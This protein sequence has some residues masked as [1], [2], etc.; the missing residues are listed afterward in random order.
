VT[1]P[2]SQRY[3]EVSGEGGTRQILELVVLPQSRKLV[4]VTDAA[5]ALRGGEMFLSDLEK[6]AANTRERLG[7]PGL[8]VW[9]ADGL[10]PGALLALIG[11]KLPH[12]KIRMATVRVLR[13]AGFEVEPTLREYHHT[14]W[15]PAGYT[16]DTLLAVADRFEP[17]IA[18]EDLTGMG[19]ITTG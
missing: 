13:E 14:I 9:A 18:R 3:S 8:S 16:P 10:A 15:L 6:N 19:R 5:I 4:R 2:G 17:P 11:T 1:A 12:P 7:R